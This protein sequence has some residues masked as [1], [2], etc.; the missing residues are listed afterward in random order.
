MN[1]SSCNLSNSDSGS[2]NAEVQQFWVLYSSIV[3]T[4]LP[5]VDPTAPSSS[6]EEYPSRG[7]G[8]KS[9]QECVLQHSLAE[10]RVLFKAGDLTNDNKRT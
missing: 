9:L 2:S 7:H 5:N 1:M 4:T 6:E 8:I 10:E 3:S